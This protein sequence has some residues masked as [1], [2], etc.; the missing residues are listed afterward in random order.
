GG[1]RV[2]VGQYLEAAVRRMGGRNG[3]PGHPRAAGVLEKV[4]ARRAG[5]VAAAQIEAVT[6]R[7]R[8]PRRGEREQESESQRRRARG[9]HEGFLWVP[10]WRAWSSRGR[11]ESSTPENVTGLTPPSPAAI[12]STLDRT[13]APA[14]SR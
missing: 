14:G 1:L 10:G 13:G 4:L 5:G 2:P 9:V 7:R 3:G 12:V 11:R 8:F 6:G